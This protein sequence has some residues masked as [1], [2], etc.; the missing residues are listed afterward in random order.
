MVL[1]PGP[2]VEGAVA[3]PPLPGPL[4]PSQPESPRQE[5]LGHGGPRRGL[6]QSGGSARR[7][8]LRGVLP[9][10]QDAPGMDE[11]RLSPA[12][13]PAV[14]VCGRIDP[15]PLTPYRGPSENDSN[16]GRRHIRGGTVPGLERQAGRLVPCCPRWPA[17][18]F[19]PMRVRCTTPRRNL[20]SPRSMFRRMQR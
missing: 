9:P 4:L 13:D 11:N 5:A 10:E 18:R 7:P 6:L 17:M 3:N 12:A 14:R 20:D 19:D 1:R 15:V 16:L 8:A 2:I